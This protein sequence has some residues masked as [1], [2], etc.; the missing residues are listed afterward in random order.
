MTAPK[1]CKTE[2]QFDLSASNRNERPNRIDRSSRIAEMIKSL[3]SMTAVVFVLFGAEAV[4]A[5]P[6]WT[7]YKQ[8]FLLPEGRVVDTGQARV[9]HTEGQGM[10]M[11]LAVHFDDQAAFNKIWQWTRRNLQVR[12]DK[13]LSWRWS[14]KDCAAETGKDCVRDKNNASDGDVFIAWALLRAHQKWKSPGHLAAA[15]EIIQAIRKQLLRKSSRGPVLIP[16]MDGF[17]RP[18]GTV[19]NLSYW[20]FPAIPDFAKVD[21]APEWLELQQAG[22]N[23]LLEAHFGRW[24]LPADWILLGNKLAPAPGFLPRFGYDAVRIPLY[25]LWAK[26][27]TPALLAPFKAYWDHFKGAKFISPWTSLDDNSIDSYDASPGLRSIAELTVAYP[28]ISTVRLP[29]LDAKQEYYSSVLLMLTK[30]ML[31]E[32][33]RK[34]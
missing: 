10:T 16:G 2:Q 34:Q 9:S 3:L 28:N 18:D 4:A 31:E 21:P 26:N 19:I 8:R 30:V 15:M 1:L 33:S 23:L 27:E 7:L 14:S 20:V 24:G 12:D 29:A 6:D 5:D 32:R 22:V 11:F 25:L 17:E 13:L